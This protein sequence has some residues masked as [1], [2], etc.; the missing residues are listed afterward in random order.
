MRS[1]TR[2]GLCFGSLSLRGPV[3]VSVFLCGPGIGTCSVTLMDLALVVLRT[4]TILRVS[5]DNVSLRAA[6]IDSYTY[7]IANSDCVTLHG[8][9]IGNVTLPGTWH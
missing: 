5:V 4:C 6:D 1:V 8:A 3:I 7:C 9:K 2:R